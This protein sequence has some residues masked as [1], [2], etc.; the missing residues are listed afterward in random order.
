MISLTRMVLLFSVLTLLAA[1]L[2]AQAPGTL[3]GQV[4]DQS[5]A[6][7]PKASVIVS[8]PNNVTKVVE[9]NNDGVYTVPGL[10]PGKYTVRVTAP[11]F[12]LFEKTLLDVAAGRPT[13][14]DIKLAVE[15]SKQEV[16]VAD[17]QQVELDPAKNAG[18]LVLK[19]TDLDMLSDDPDDL[20][21]ELLALA[22][23]AAGPNGGQIFIDGFSGGQLPPKDSIREIRINSNPFSAE[24]DTSGR[25]RI[26]IFTKPGSEKFHGSV[27]LSY[28]D[29]WFNARNPYIT[30]PAFPVPASDTKNLSANLSGPVIKG[31]LSFFVD[32]SRRQQ[33]ED[34]II[35]AVVLSPALV[36]LQEGFAVIAPNSNNRFSPRFTYQLTPNISLDGRYSIN[37]SNQQNQGIGGTSLPA[38][39]PVAG[40]TTSS[41]AQH[42]TSNNQNVNLIET[43]I[44][45]AATINETRFQYS[46]NRNNSVG[47]NPELNI[48]VADAFTSGSTIVQ[49]Y[50]NSDMYELQN[51]TSITHGTHFIKFGARIRGFNTAS[52]ATSNFLGQFNFLNIGAYQIMQQGIAAGLPLATIIANGGGPYQYQFNAGNPLVSGSQVDAGPFVQDDW[53]V[54]P[55]ITL[56]LGLRYEVQN[57][58]DNRSDFAPRIGLAWGVG[59]SQ[60]RVRTPKTV[61]RAGYGWFYDRFS[62]NNVLNADRFNGINQLAYTIPNPTF[63][64][65]AGVPIPATATLESPQYQQSAATYHIDSQWRAPTMMQAAIGI[66]RQLP[67]NTTLSLNY[68]S[69]RGEHILQTVDIN[70]P[71]PG[72]YNPLNPGAAV[73]PLGAATGLYQLYEPSG[74]YKQNQFIVNINSRISSKFSLFG[75]Y[76]YGH[77]STDVNGT[78]SNPYNFHQDW[79][80][81]NYDIRNRV[82]INGSLVLPFGLRMSPNITYNSAPPFNIT[83]GIDVVGDRVTNSR[84]ALAPSGFAGPPCTATLAGNL[85]PCLASGGIYGNFV[86]NPQAAGLTPLAINAFRAAQQFQFNVRLSRTW[87]F[88]E[89]TTPTNNRRGQDGG[90]RGPGFGQAAGGPRGGGGPGGGGRGGGGGPGPGGG[91][92]GEQSGKRYTVTAG[93]FV[94]NMFNNVNA[95][96][97]VGDLL[98]PRFGTTENLA[99]IGGPGSTA[100]NRRIDLNVRFSF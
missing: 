7:V 80:P 69:S 5:G 35:N 25:G 41:S 57:N 28:S 22:G 79:G 34:D 73:Y 95:G 48:S 18:A 23:P 99:N 21:A 59:P 100:F 51:Y 72:T 54:K 4:L 47:D 8:G 20:Q 43:Q 88:G 37:T 24:Y 33:R 50:T 49:N 19:E 81:A 91:M 82:N 29:H 98:S 44:V 46:R 94:H 11:G 31:K 17:T 67:R 56:S 85:T 63:F 2:A 74:D 86:I 65:Q 70:T 1:S 39:V 66:D 87:G 42:S 9:T 45:N 92:G 75:F 10:P 76:A 89:S 32:Y 6:S 68:I 78:P 61:I 60:G 16:T 40:V 27:N 83:Q 36:P 93:I 62:L 13:A 3:Q 12:T 71:L 14:L 77:V 90:G 96:L 58:V 15:I 53:R 97:P 55:N 84:P 26:E 30:S 38:G 64:P 52:A